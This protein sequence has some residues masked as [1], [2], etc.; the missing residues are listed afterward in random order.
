MKDKTSN[1][2]VVN[3][4][5]LTANVQTFSTYAECLKS[6]GSE[7]KIVN[8]LNNL[9][10]TPLANDALKQL[11]SIVNA[12]SKVPY[13][14]HEATAGPSKGKQVRNK[15][16]AA[17]QYITRV[18]TAQPELIDAVQ[19]E[20]NKKPVLPSLNRTINRPAK[21]PTPPTKTQVEQAKVMLA[22]NDKLSKF[23]KLANAIGQA[24]SKGANQEENESKLSKVVQ[25]VHQATKA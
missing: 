3:G 2:L 5:Q 22:D 18:L 9:V 20:M 17:K 19:A 10:A 16:D 8:K 24:F 6:A 21:A 15:D 7:E 25:A 12:L 11:D 4:K 13:N 1:V 23:L 14:T